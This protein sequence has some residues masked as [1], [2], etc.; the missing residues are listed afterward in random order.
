MKTTKQLFITLCLWLGV[1]SGLF[2]FS[3]GSIQY[4]IISDNQVT[5]RYCSD[6]IKGHVVIPQTVL[7]EGKDYTVTEISNNAF[8]NCSGLTG[9]TIPESV[10][11]ISDYVF[12]ECTGLTSLT[13]NAIECNKTSMHGGSI[14]WTKLTSVTIGPKVTNIPA[15][16]LNGCTGLTNV[17]IPESVT[18]IGEHA[19]GNCQGLTSITIPEGVTTIDQNAF[20]QCTGLTTLTY[21]AIECNK[22]SLYYNFGWSQLTAVTFGPKV[23]FLPHRLFSECTL[24]T[25]VTIPESVTTIGQSTFSGCTGLT[26]IILPENVTTIGQN[27]FYGCTGLSSI[28]IPEKVKSIGNNAFGSCTRMTSLFY[29]AIDCTIEDSYMSSWNNLTSVT[30]GLKVRTIPP[31][32]LAE[33]TDLISVTI[34]ESVKTIGKDV[35]QNCTGLTSITLPGNV[36][37]VGDNAFYGCTNLRYFTWHALAGAD[38]G[39]G[40]IGSCYNL[41]QLSGPAKLLHVYE[42]LN[43]TSLSNLETVQFTGGNMTDTCYAVLKASYRNLKTVDLSNVSNTTLDDEAFLNFYRLETITLPDSLTQIGYKSLAECAGLKSITIPETVELIDARAFENCYNMTTI[44]WGKSSVLK[45]IGA[46]AFFNCHSLQSLTVPEGVTEI[47]LAAFQGCG[48]LE[49]ITLP[50]TLS[51]LNDRSFAGNSRLKQLVVKAKVPPTISSYT[52]EEVD[53]SIP[54]YIPAEAIDAYQ[55]DALW[56]RFN[57]VPT[58]LEHMKNADVQLTVEGRTLTIHGIDQPSI[59]VFDVSGRLIVK[60]R[61]NQVEMPT[62]G[63]YMVRVN[64]TTHKVVVK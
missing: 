17:T 26:N 6:T 31:S 60:G 49:A 22:E 51:L 41:E 44:N 7:F 55:A 59:S 64:G 5:I 14:G 42:G 27:A 2:A 63:M 47:G 53:H 13:Y 35:F 32:M 58:G 3:I 56:S 38:C 9:I 50:S 29:N 20:Y 8:R 30:F 23:T 10:T 61:A 11:T 33:C 45:S 25:N 57:L 1:H 12:Y 46:R 36:E 37:Y 40:V 28:N 16:F 54:V 21:N 48:Y 43:Y 15:G 19:F 4:D 52:F 34:P 18:E 24:L 39:Y 62:S